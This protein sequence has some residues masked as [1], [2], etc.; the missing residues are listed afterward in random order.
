MSIRFGPRDI[1]FPSQQ[2][3][4]LRDSNDLLGDSAAL[5]Q[6]ME[7]DGYLL[8]RGALDRET[9]M[10]GRRTVLEHIALHEGLV[11]GTP[12]LDGVMPPGTR[13]R[14][15]VRP[16]EITH[17]PD[18]LAVLESPRLFE[19]YQGLF[20]APARTFNYKWLR[21]VGN[22]KHTPAHMDVIYVGRGTHQRCTCW[23]PIG[24][25]DLQI[26]TLAICVGSHRLESYAHMRGTYG[27]MDMDRDGVTGRLSEDP[28][29]FVEHYGGQWQTTEF[30][31]GDL[32]TFGLFTLH[33][34]I[35]NMTNRYRISADVRFQPAHLPIDPRFVGDE[36]RGHADAVTDPAKQVTMEQ[37]K[38]EWGLV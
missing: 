34:S 36:P 3:G 25:L 19:F 10:R 33:A 12:V 20:G 24:D 29:H 30:R 37:K 9:V 6:R 16:R 13:E 21:A 1:A 35:T 15:L 32:L 38:V 23:I 8:L 28:L 7:E 31:A 5:G 14:T 22:A 27:R 17:H 18:V 2:M 4:E 11:P 26:G